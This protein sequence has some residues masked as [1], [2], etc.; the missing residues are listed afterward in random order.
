MRI[1]AVEATRATLELSMD[2]LVL[3]MNALWQELDSQA[4]R[5]GRLDEDLRASYDA[6]QADLGDVI[7]EMD[8]AADELP[9]VWQPG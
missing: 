9:G 3:L 6:L 8:A 7:S 2:E 4:R 5:R 1:V